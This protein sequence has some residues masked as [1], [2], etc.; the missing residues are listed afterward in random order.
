MM[1]EKMQKNI[2]QYREE[3]KAGNISLITTW[4]AEN[5]H[6]KGDLHDPL[7]LIEKVTGDSLN[8]KPFLRY[9]NE[10][11]SKLYGY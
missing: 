6:S 5:V 7:D 8:V 1:F 4:L 9:L 10:K 3:I 11:Y 2:P